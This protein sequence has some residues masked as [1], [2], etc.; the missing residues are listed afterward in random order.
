MRSEIEDSLQHLL[1]KQ[2][3]N[4]QRLEQKQ[5]ELEDFQNGLEEDGLDED[6]E[7]F[8]I[9]DEYLRSTDGPE[10]P[11]SEYGYPNH[12]SGQFECPICGDDN[13]DDAIHM[14]ACAHIYHQDC[15][16]AWVN[17]TEGTITENSVSTLST[18]ISLKRDTLLTK[19]KNM[20]PV[21]REWLCEPRGG[22]K[23]DVED[24][25]Y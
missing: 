19:R 3:E 12:I 15:I 16:H 1:A 17:G 24:I 6:D 18:L 23:D 10:V 25:Y 11:T 7:E 20:C 9:V 13:Q 21:C 5:R 8:E 22:Y 14:Y 2:E 4:R